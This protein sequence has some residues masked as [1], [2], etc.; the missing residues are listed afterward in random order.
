MQVGAFYEIYAMIT[1]EQQ[2]GEV[3]I[4]HLCQTIL[5]IA[6]VTNP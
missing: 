4:Y 6:V 1:D 3:N 5:N 2:L